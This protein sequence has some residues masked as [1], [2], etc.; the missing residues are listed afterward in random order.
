MK[1]I[2][3][4]IIVSI[5]V[6]TMLV[7]LKLIVG[8]IT[9]YKSIIADAVHSFSD[10]STD[11]VA[12]LGQ[13]LSLKKPDNNHPYGHGKI[14]YITSIV[15]GAV[16]MALGIEL[17]IT[18]IT[19]KIEVFHNHSL[20]LIVVAITIISKF[21]LAKYIEHR[22]KKYNNAILIASSKESMAD[23]LSSIGVF[24]TIILSL[25]KEQ[26]PI[27]AYADKVGGLIISM[28]IIKTSLNILRDNVNAI[29]GESEQNEEVINKIRD[30]IM[31]VRG[32][33]T[34]DELTIMKFGS[35]YQVVLDVGIDSNCELEKAH[36]IAHDVE[37]KL[38]KSKFVIKYVSIHMNPCE[39][40]IS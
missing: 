39:K 2:Y 29:I 27:L 7:L 31:E 10:L 21:L 38:L 12:L 17:I 33:L 13:R 23:A 18:T 3:K 22:S 35:Y 20:A 14:Q 4:T 11:I 19:S 28:F 37:E 36:A 1:K 24:L 8:F 25:F 32:I 26:I 34:I 5:T 40:S 6:N 16:I 15:I 30:I 9:N